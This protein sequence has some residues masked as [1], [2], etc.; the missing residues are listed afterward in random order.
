MNRSCFFLIAVLLCIGA[1]R[2]CLG[3]QRH[4]D[5][6]VKLTSTLPDPVERCR[7]LLE[8]SQ[9]YQKSDSTRSAAYKQ[10]AVALSAKLNDDQQRLHANLVFAKHYLNNRSFGEARSYT[11]K[12]LS[13][14]K[15]DGNKKDLATILYY[16]GCIYLSQ[17]DSK[18]ALD[19]FIR[20]YKLAETAGDT[21][22]KAHVNSSFG[23]IY[24]QQGQLD[25]ALLYYKK[26][27]D[28]FES[29]TGNSEYSMSGSQNIGNILLAK[30]SFSEGQAYLK[31]ALELAKQRKDMNAEMIVLG[32][33]SNGYEREGKLELAALYATELVKDAQKS[34]FLLQELYGKTLL[35]TIKLDEKKYDEAILKAKEA[36]VLAEQAQIPDFIVSLYEMLVAGYE[37][38]GDFQQAYHYKNKLVQLKDSLSAIENK[39]YIEEIKHKYNLQQK[40]QELLLKTELIQQ[41]EKT[42]KQKTVIIISLLVLGV[43]GLLSAFLFFQRRKI[44][45]ELAR[46]NTVLENQN[47]NFEAFINGQE[48]ERKRIASDL[49]DGLAQN[50]VMLKMGIRNFNLPDKEQQ[51]KLN[52]YSSELDTMIEETRRISHN[53]MPGVLVDL[54]LVKALKS[55]VAELNANHPTL[56]TTLSIS[57]P[58][59]T[60]PSDL[61]IQVYRI[62]QELLNNVIK[63][64]GASNCDIRLTSNASG[65]YVELK[66]NGKGFDTKSAKTG[67]GLQNIQS[68]VNSLNGK[69]SIDSASGKGT[70]VSFR[71][72]ITD[73][74]WKTER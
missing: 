40:N 74:A 67:I 35:S 21:D 6:L 39:S 68:R 20:S 29:T 55:L 53:M 65:I 47:K 27:F 42:G 14:V 8:L 60:L 19:E 45:E 17:G 43:S 28:Y 22:L 15:Q 33:I 26:S 71:I 32:N 34:G 5:S 25:S 50:L 41:I 18:K 37:Q 36:L 11:D 58:F 4:L 61:E 46:K 31:R 44:R 66:D 1:S 2:L 62:I 3:Q 16:S 23:V 73:R 7:I 24:Q 56:Q 49:H 30:G 54:G 57:E 59:A 52:Y 9:L 51:E 10:K 69:L 72:G 63:H 48:E 70:S 12:A 13:L 38:K 64:S